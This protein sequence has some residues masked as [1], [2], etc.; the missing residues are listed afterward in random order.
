MY[1]LS[2]L[3]PTY[4]LEVHR[5]IDAAR[6]HTCK[7]RTKY[8]YCSCIYSKNVVVFDDVEQI[9]SHLVCR[10]F[11]KDYMICVKH[12]D[13]SSVPY[14]IGHLAD[15]NVE[16]PNMPIEGLMCMQ[17]DQIWMLREQI[18]YIRETQHHCH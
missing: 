16:A 7:E 14:A 13:G 11:I 2:R 15:T 8:I 6:M 10:G 12:G 1:N 17:R 9:I 4:Q 18:W 5:F 3:D